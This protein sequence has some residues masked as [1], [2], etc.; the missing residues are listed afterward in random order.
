MNL[1]A[2]G[3]ECVSRNCS[4]FDVVSTEDAGRRHHHLLPSSA[5]AGQTLANCTFVYDVQTFPLL[6]LGMWRS[7]SPSSGSTA[8]RCNLLQSSAFRSSQ[9]RGLVRYCPGHPAQLG[10]PRCRSLGRLEHVK[11]DS[12]DFSSSLMSERFRIDRR[13]SQPRGNRHRRTKP[14]TPHSRAPRRLPRGYPGLGGPSARGSIVSG[15]SSSS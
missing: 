7:P 8:S 13:S 5:L 9:P 14:C 15:T 11:L 12:P 2:I 1:E 3:L 4:G 10:Y 6:A